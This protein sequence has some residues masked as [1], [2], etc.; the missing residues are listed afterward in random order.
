M[1][2][3][4]PVVLFLLAGCLPPTNELPSPLDLAAPDAAERIARIEASIVPDGGEA[5][6]LV[7]RMRQLDIPAVSVAVFEKGSI[8]WAKAWGMADREEV[9]PAATNTLFQAASIS[10]P[11]AAAAMLSLVED[12]LLDLDADVNAYLTRWKVPE[13]EFTATEKVTLRRIVNHTAGTTVWGFP[14]YARTEV[15]PPTIGVLDGEG[16]TDSVRVYKKPG[17]SWQYSGGGYT[18]L[19]LVLEDVT[20][21]PFPDLVRER[22]LEPSDMSSSGYLQPLPPARW[23]DAA[24]GY[25]EDGRPVEG[26]WHVYPEMA[27]AGLWTTPSD[28]ARFAMAV[29]N[30]LQGAGTVLDSATVREML[31]PGMENHGLGPMI[32]ADGLQFRHGGA[33]EG[34]RCALIAFIDGRGGVA[35]MTNSDAGGTVLGEVR[36]AVAKEY[37]WPNP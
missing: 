33:N 5:V 23:A 2:R 8:S 13:N 29:Q 7:D 3:M 35:I 12:G 31:T 9:R 6:T 30:D 25:R 34:F 37:G 26:Q 20:G 1:K 24:T 19:Q 4:I 21:R 15:L 16:N 17:E 10:K 27:A 36:D 32:S 11:V 14:G 18:V 22:V 28:L